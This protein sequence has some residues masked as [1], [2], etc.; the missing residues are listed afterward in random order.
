MIASAISRIIA[1]VSRWSSTGNAAV[2]PHRCPASPIS[3]GASLKYRNCITDSEPIGQSAA[4]N[5]T[6]AAPQRLL[7]DH[8]DH[9]A[10]VK[11]P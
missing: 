1:R 4:L 9:R 5:Y 2:W 3:L 11:S 8:R 6:I 10:A 7:S